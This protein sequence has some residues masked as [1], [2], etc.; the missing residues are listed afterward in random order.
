MPQQQHHLDGLEAEAITIFRECPRPDAKAVI[1]Y[2]IGKDSSE[3]LHV[4]TGW[5][6]REMY[7]PRDRAAQALHQLYVQLGD[8]L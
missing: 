6:F 3:L 8:S 2:S 1:L 5:K 7:E 4:D